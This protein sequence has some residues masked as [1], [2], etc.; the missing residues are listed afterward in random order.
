VSKH[1]IVEAGGVEAIILAMHSHPADPK[2]FKFACATLTNICQ[3]AKGL[4]LLGSNQWKEAIVTRPACLPP[5]YCSLSKMRQFCKDCLPHVT[6]L[7][8]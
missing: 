8:L 2:V 5:H 7:L 4:M 3:T 1:I 6:A